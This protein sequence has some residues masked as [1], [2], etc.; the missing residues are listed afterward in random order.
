MPDRGAV[1]HDDELLELFGDDP[2]GLAIVDAIAATQKMRSSPRRVGVVALVAAV[3]V[4][5]V[6]VAALTRSTSSAGVI[7][8][9]L[10]RVPGSGVIRIVLTDR[11]PAFVVVDLHSGRRAPAHHTISEWVNPVTG[12][13]RIVDSVGATV[14]SDERLAS[15]KPAEAVK[16]LNVAGLD[17][18]PTLYRTSLEHATERDVRRGTANGQAVYWIHFPTR[19]AI[20]EV[21]VARG[22]FQPVL[23]RFRNAAGQSRTFV[24]RRF[25]GAAD[26]EVPAAGAVSRLRPSAVVSSRRLTLAAAVATIG[27]EPGQLAPGFGV[28]SARRT[29]LRDGAVVDDVL[30]ADTVAQ[31]RLPERFTRVE[32]A[33]RPEAGVGWTDAVSR[34][35]RPGDLVARQT[36]SF[37][38]G[39]LTHGGRFI[40]LTTSQGYADL[41][42][43]ARALVT[44]H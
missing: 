26:A 37:W 17:R 6:A 35:V 15:G 9:A 13:R 27:S 34:L 5:S 16:G 21:A 2:E 31:G 14:V 11:R 12:V 32:A 3:V 28:A 39:Y 25:G 1:I 18:V 44:S 36:G 41:L 7:Q 43:T 20:S 38:E 40:R 23:I 22:S 30:L 24:V 19:G 10:S 33:A 42:R 4:I 8:K 29:Q